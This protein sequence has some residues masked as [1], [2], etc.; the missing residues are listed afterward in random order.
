[1]HSTPVELPSQPHPSLVRRLAEGPFASFV[2]QLPNLFLRFG[3][4]AIL[5][6]IGLF[7]FTAVEAAGIHPLVAHSPFMSWLYAVLSERGVSNL[8]G[9]TEVATAVMLLS[10]RVRP[11]LA[12]LGG[13]AGMAI[14]TLT[15][16][17]LVTTPGVWVSVPGF[18]IPVPGETG[19]FLIKD[20]FL[21]GA[22]AWCTRE[23]LRTVRNSDRLSPPSA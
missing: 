1:V 5:M 3:L 14:F 18:P 19:W 4:V 6:Y 17:F 20:L 7:K 16:S 15:L 11:E 12:V 13:I 23:S 10:W 22:A 21:L 9:T 2:D 8:I